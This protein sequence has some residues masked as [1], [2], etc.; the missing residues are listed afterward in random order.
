MAK[1]TRVV[2][3]DERG[4]RVEY[5]GREWKITLVNLK[6]GCSR[7]RLSGYRSHYKVA[8]CETTHLVGATK[9]VHN[10]KYRQ[11]KPGGRK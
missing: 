11:F 9:Q 8:A 1:I 2:L 4:R 5:N 3:Y 10:S 7:I 6:C